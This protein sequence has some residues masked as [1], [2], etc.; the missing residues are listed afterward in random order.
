MTIRSTLS[1]R[2]TCV[3]TA[4]VLSMLMSACSSSG[5]GGGNEQVNQFGLADTSNLVNVDGVDGW[6]CFLTNSDIFAGYSYFADST[7]RYLSV[8]AA[9][10]GTFSI[11]GFVPFTYSLTSDTSLQILYEFRD[12]TSLQENLTSIAFVDR[13]EF[14]AISDVEGDIRCTRR[15]V[16]SNPADV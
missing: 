2:I 9:G 7:G 8:T 11:N 3:F 1:K 10:D 4:M 6:V 12:G 5:S 13:G 14:N 16:I 15:E